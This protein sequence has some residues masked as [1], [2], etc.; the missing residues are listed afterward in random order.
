MDT[1]AALLGRAMKAHAE[2]TEIASSPTLRHN[3]VAKRKAREAEHAVLRLVQQLRTTQ[4]A[5]ERRS[6]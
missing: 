6:A 5:N 3:A 1:Y 2:I 4:R